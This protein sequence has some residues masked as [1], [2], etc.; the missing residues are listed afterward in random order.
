MYVVYDS[1][2]I[3]SPILPPSLPPIFPPMCIIRLKHDQAVM[4]LGQMDALGAPIYGDWDSDAGVSEICSLRLEYL[5]CVVLKGF[6]SKDMLADLL[7]WDTADPKGTGLVFRPFFGEML[8]PPDLPRREEFKNALMS[9]IIKTHKN[10]IEDRNVV[11]L[12][13]NNLSAASQLL[14]RRLVQL[15]EEEKVSWESRGLVFPVLRNTRHYLRQIEELNEVWSKPF[16]QLLPYPS[17]TS[18]PRKK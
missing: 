3:L 17:G 7:A 4:A 18:L 13:N 6:F 10:P 14:R 2:S 9:V 5:F 12:F 15:I 1:S 11:R 16:S 8:G